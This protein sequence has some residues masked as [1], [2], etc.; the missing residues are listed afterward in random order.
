MFKTMNQIKLIWV[1]SRSGWQGH[2]KAM[3]KVLSALLISLSCLVE[4][5]LDSQ[6]GKA[7]LSYSI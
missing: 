1:Q 3:G 4:L 7:C 2:P 5:C 6:L